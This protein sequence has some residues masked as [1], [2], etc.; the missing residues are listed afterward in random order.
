VKLYATPGYVIIKEPR[1][2]N[3]TGFYM[4]R[5]AAGLEGDLEA[6]YHM[7]T[8]TRAFVLFDVTYHSVPMS[9]VLTFWDYKPE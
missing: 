1:V 2:N 9:N 7:G 4:G 3:D 5:V 6:L 8:N